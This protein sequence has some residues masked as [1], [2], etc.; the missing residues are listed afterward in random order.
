LSIYASGVSVYA[1][2]FL[3]TI[4][5]VTFN[6]LCISQWSLPRGSKVTGEV[7]NVQDAIVVG[8]H[9]VIG[10]RDPGIKARERATEISLID[11][12]K[13]GFRQDGLTGCL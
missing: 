8:S 3:S 4:T 9:A 7:Y 1:L 13:V 6:R 5:D 10:Y 11:L 2:K 12:C